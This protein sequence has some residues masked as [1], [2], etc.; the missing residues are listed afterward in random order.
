MASDKPVF[1]IIS[2][3]MGSY[4]KSDVP[5][6]LMG[7]AT[8]VIKTHPGS[9]KSRDATGV[10][11]LAWEQDGRKGLYLM[12][13]H[14][15][16]NERLEWIK[17]ESLEWNHWQA[18]AKDCERNKFSRAG[19][20]GQGTCT[21][22]RGPLKAT[23]PTLAPIEY[24]LPGSPDAFEPLVPIVREFDFFII[25]EMDFR[26]L[27]EMIEVSREDVARTAESHPNQGIVL[28]CDVLRLL[29]DKLQD[30]GRL[31][32]P[33]LYKA[34]DS[35]LEA[36]GT[37]TASVMEAV[38]AGK[39][40]NMP[41]TD[42][43]PHNFAP[44]LLSIIWGE[45]G[46]SGTGRDFNPRLHLVSEPGRRVMRIWWRKETWWE[47]PPTFIMDAT[48]DHKLLSHTFAV[49]DMEEVEA[50]PWPKNVHVYQWADDLVTRWTLGIKGRTPHSQTGR[51]QRRKWYERIAD[52]LP[53]DRFP[54]HWPVGV[55]THLTIEKEAKN[56]ITEMGFSDVRAL[57]Y[58]AE[59]GSNTMEDVKVLVLLGLIIPNANEFEEE[60]SA[61]LWDEGPLDFAWEK[62][63]Q[64]L[65]M[66]DGSI[67]Q[68][69]VKGHWKEPVAS[70]YKQKCQFGL[71]Q[72]IHRIRPYI[73]KEYDRYVFIFT[74]MPIPGVVIDDVLRSEEGERIA[75]RATKAASTLNEQLESNG[76]CD[77]PDLAEAITGEGERQR[78]VSKWIGEN[79]QR[80]A[81]DTCSI[82]TSGQGKRPGRFTKEST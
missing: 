40:S 19:Y 14:D 51:A 81:A 39:R 67:A 12:L 2:S 60:A 70:Y 21:C 31:N 69:E 62:R 25:D 7:Y 8:D 68:V 11:N 26:R 3:K 13:S 17:E 59:R 30:G 4:S 75:D 37:N 33:D 56:A 36:R 66:R 49:G 52:A 71:Y 6:Y 47:Q 1:K 77:V 41:W 5:H 73:D 45:L 46:K 50:P 58:G 72:A 79:S 9:G 23:G 78:T 22:G 27:L 20:V 48:A 43:A 64:P 32:G 34:I 55:I 57:H 44:T 38:K 18:H 82:Y 53:A 61:Y 28:L 63:L 54:R 42:D 10:I 29:L 24:I 65:T 15:A 76:A 74:N 35:E 80:L 16:I